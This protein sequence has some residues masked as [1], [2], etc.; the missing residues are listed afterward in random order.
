ML[1]GHEMTKQPAAKPEESAKADLQSGN[2][3]ALVADIKSYIDH[4]ALHLVKENHRLFMMA[5]IILQ[6]KAQQV[7]KDLAQSEEAKLK[8]LGKT[9]SHY[10]KLVGDVESSL[11]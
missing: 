5:D 7:S 4:V 8:E 1:F 10:E 6:G 2:S 9:R 3:D 11:V